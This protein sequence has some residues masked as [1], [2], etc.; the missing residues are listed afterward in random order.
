MQNIFYR[1]VSSF[2]QIPSKFF[3]MERNKKKEGEWKLNIEKGIE[4]K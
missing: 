4:N 2:F 1:K 3:Y